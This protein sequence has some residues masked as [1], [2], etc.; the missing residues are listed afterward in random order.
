[1]RREDRTTALSFGFALACCCCVE[2]L[3]QSQKHAQL[4]S[5]E[6]SRGLHATLNAEHGWQG[7]GHLETLTFRLMNDSDQTLD[8]ATRSWVL[9]IDDKQAPD[10]GGQLWMGGKPTGG[11]D[12]VRP[13]TTYQF[14]KA[15]PLRQYFPEARDYKVYWKATGFRSNVVVVRGQ[16]SP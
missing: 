8:S 1:M 7:D 5:S 3:G 6:S 16:A 13:G 10:P 4:D 15:L 14:G 2:L 12:T 11:Y 9:I